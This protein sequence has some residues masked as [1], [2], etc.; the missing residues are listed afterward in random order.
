MNKR[1]KVIKI[2][3]EISKNYDFLNNII[4]FGMCHVWQKRLEQKIEDHKNCEKVLDLCTGTGELLFPLSK[5]SKE[6]FALDIS[7]PM[8]EIARERANKKNIK[9]ILIEGEA[10]SLPFEDNAF[11]LITVAYGVRNFFD[12]SLGLKEMSRVLKPKGCVYIL[13]F[14]KSQNKLWQKIFS[15]YF[16][17]IMPV[18]VKIFCP[19]DEAYNYLTKSVLNFPS[20]D[21]FVSILYQNGL[22]CEYFDTMLLGTVYIYTC[23]KM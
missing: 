12:I 23:S 20:G 5:V 22:K 1:Q 2:F 8:L 13:E 6:L 10:E 15:I 9:A 16:S 21:D 7:K 3:S 4:S 17:Y 14:G 18:L 11:D 19:Y